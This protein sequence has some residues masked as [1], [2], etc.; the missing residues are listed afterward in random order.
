MPA[1]PKRQR[2][3]LLSPASGAWDGAAADSFKPDAPSSFVEAEA[4]STADSSANTWAAST[5]SGAKMAT[6][7]C[8]SVPPKS[9][10]M[11]ALAGAG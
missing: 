8:S 2:S 11:V 10:E 7:T 9:G 5:R 1:S 3:R 4:A 6:S